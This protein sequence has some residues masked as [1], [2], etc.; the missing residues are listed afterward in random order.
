MA[1]LQACHD[2]YAAFQR[3]A[4]RVVLTPEHGH[5]KHYLGPGGLEQL[6]EW[7]RYAFPEIVF[8]SV[9]TD[10]GEVVL[11]VSHSVELPRK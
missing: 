9:K 10:R 7:V 8:E 5:L 3:G 11:T 4:D 6:L 2:L 1:K